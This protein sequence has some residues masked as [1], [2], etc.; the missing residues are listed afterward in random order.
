MSTNAA[1]SLPMKLIT[2]CYNF[3]CC[4][5]T[6]SLFKLTDGILVLPLTSNSLLN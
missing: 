4:K 5:H 3:N 2:M 1:Y 6:E